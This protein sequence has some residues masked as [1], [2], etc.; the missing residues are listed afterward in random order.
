MLEKK[1]G[2]REF[3]NFQEFTCIKIS[4]VAGQHSY[5]FFYN[6]DYFLLEL[7][8]ALSDMGAAEEIDFELCLHWNYFIKPNHWRCDHCGEIADADDSVMIYAEEGDGGVAR[9]GIIHSDECEEWAE[10][11]GRGEK[12]KVWL[13]STLAFLPN[14][15]SCAFKMLRN[16][17]ARIS[18]CRAFLRGY[19]EMLNINP[20]DKIFKE[21]EFPPQ[22]LIAERIAK[23]RK[24][25]RDFVFDVTEMLDVLGKMRFFAKEAYGLPFYYESYINL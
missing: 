17:A 10:P 4:Q 9:C 23:I 6:S 1:L 25:R 16:D 18:I 21:F 14:E 22:R 13:M 15:L 2:K 20:Y 19:E 5:A 8:K 24:N 3:V 7:G 11:F 12:V